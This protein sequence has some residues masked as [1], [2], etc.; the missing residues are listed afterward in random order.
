MSDAKLRDKLISILFMV[1]VIAFFSLL[2]L[3]ELWALKALGYNVLGH[4]KGTLEAGKNIQFTFE[5]LGV[6]AFI[7]GQPIIFSLLLIFLVRK[8]LPELAKASSDVIIGM[9]N[10][11]L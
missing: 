2:T 9:V 8:L 7:V 1:G 4:L 6:L 3:V 11:W 10:L 5:A